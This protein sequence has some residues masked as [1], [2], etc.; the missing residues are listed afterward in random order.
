AVEHDTGAAEAGIDLDAGVG[1]RGADHRAGLGRGRDEG[2]QPAPLICT[3]GSSGVRK[4]PMPMLIPTARTMIASRARSS[5]ARKRAEARAPNWA[6]IT[7][8]IS[9]SVAS[10]MSTVWLRPA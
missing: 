6:P 9:S 5:S 2:H 1:E 7:P 3:K 8:P 10:T 4:R